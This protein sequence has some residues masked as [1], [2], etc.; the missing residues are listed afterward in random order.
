MFQPMKISQQGRSLL[1][2]REGRVLK[3]YRDSRGIWSIGVGHTSMAGAPKVVQN[4]VI[5]EA[6]CDAIFSKDLLPSENAVNAVLARAN[7]RITQS[8]FDALI[9]FVHNIGVGGFN[10]STVAKRLVSN[11]MAG[12]PSA[13]L[14]WNEPPEIIGRRKQEAEQFREG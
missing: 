7:L 14:M 13:M 3:A 10:T 8:Q 6:Q 12:I 11:D 2:L 4:L 9:S 5:S 1:T